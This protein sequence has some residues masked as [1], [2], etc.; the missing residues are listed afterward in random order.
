LCGEILSVVLG[1]AGAVQV[2]FVL[3]GPRGAGKS[4]IGARLA[5]KLQAAFVDLDIQIEHLTSKSI[6]EIFADE[7]NQAEGHG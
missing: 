3:I 4:K 6:A 1:N 5:S 2:I 7:G